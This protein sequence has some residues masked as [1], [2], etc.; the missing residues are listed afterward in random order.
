MDEP[1]QDL[2]FEPE[3][4]V[5]LLVNILENAC[6]FSPRRSAIEIK[7][8]SYFWERRSPTVRQRI[9]HS[10]RRRR[11]EARMN[12]YRI[13]IVDSGPGILP[14]HLNQIFE[15]YTS[16]SGGNDRSGTGLGLAISK[17]I[18]H[19]HHG[20]IWAEPRKQGATFSFVLPYAVAGDRRELALAVGSGD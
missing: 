19:L 16:Y 6:R 8:Y 14:E 5:Q 15:E 13:D 18:V 1:D 20:R 2:F 7:G 10:N 17:G 3:Q 9:S 11:D 12:C 4:I